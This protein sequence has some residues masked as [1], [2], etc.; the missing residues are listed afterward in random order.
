MIGKSFH[1]VV[2]EVLSKGLKRKYN[3]IQIKKYG[4]ESNYEYSNLLRPFSMDTFC[5]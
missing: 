3:K 4:L 5:S 1:T 2:Q